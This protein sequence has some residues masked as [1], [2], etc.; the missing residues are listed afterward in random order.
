M[1]LGTGNWAKL[2]YDIYVLDCTLRI[3]ILAKFSKYHKVTH[4]LTCFVNL[5]AFLDM[6]DIIAVAQQG[7][8]PFSSD[9]DSSF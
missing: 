4:P 5:A 8:H 7:S 3:E 9:N 1:R 2:L 6:K